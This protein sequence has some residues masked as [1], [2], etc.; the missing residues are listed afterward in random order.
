M[1]SGR[2]MV[3]QQ[4]L[5]AGKANHTA[6]SPEPPEGNA[7]LLILFSSLRPGLD[8]DLQ[9]MTMNDCS[10]LLPCLW[11]FAI[12]AESYLYIRLTLTLQPSLTMYHEQVAVH[13]ASS[14]YLPQSLQM[15]LKSARHQVTPSP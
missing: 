2:N 9:N 14:T 3:P 12:I 4:C 10:L 11:S 7:D 13:A 6:S 1:A 15:I 8:L 5:E